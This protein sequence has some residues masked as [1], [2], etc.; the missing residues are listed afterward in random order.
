[1][2][3]GEHDLSVPSITFSLMYYSLLSELSADTQVL[4]V[5]DAAAPSETRHNK[6][7]FE[8]VL[9]PEWVGTFDYYKSQKTYGTNLLEKV[10][11]FDP[12]IVVCS[13]DCPSFIWPKL[14][15]KRKFILEAHNT[16]WLMGRPPSS[17]KGR[18]RRKVMEY[19]VSNIDAAI[20]TSHECQ[21]QISLLTAGQ[22]DG[23]VH[24]PQI[25]NRYS[26]AK[27]RRIRNFLYLGRIEEPKGVFLMVE[28]FSAVRD[29]NPGMSLTLTIAGTGSANER[30]I[31]KLL[32]MGEADIQF[33]GRLSSDQ[34]HEVISSSDIILFPTMTSFSE[35]LG[36]VGFEA[37]AHGIPTLMSSIVPA[38]D[39]LG[40]SCMSFEA[41][42]LAAFVDCMNTLLR[43][44]RVYQSM[45]SNI[46]TVRDKLYDRSLSMGSCL[47]KAMQE[48]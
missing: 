4:S 40:K 16:F 45:L 1:M 12:H 14:G 15:K 19:L 22:I 26:L 38:R 6:I 48:L 41:D 10:E 28:A 42:N 11:E 17:V 24:F 43:D 46:H 34:V 20:C 36:L 18:I 35:G 32:E 44:E 13:T 27:R 21:R 39:L 29:Q 5:R 30:L 33:V 47:A 7:I 8:K 31:S 25:A 9:R 37:A 2:L 23:H 3:K